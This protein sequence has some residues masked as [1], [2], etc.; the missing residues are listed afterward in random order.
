M[1]L[2]LLGW[3]VLVFSQGGADS[4]YGAKAHEI[5]GQVRGRLET[6]SH[7]HLYFTEF[8]S[9]EHVLMIVAQFTS[10]GL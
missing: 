7:F 8:H 5:L 10:Q 2:N 6:C 1:M 9:A 3:F 4:G